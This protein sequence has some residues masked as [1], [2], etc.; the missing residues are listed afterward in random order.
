MPGRVDGVSGR[1]PVLHLVTSG[2]AYHSRPSFFLSIALRSSSV[3]RRPRIIQRHPDALNQCPLLGVK[4]TL[5]KRPPMSAFD[6]KRTL[7][8]QDCCRAN[9]LS[10]IWPIAEDAWR[11]LEA[12][13]CHGS[14]PRHDGDA[15]HYDKR[16]HC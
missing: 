14:R 16:H 2:R 12:V 9:F 13:D 5:P 4:R 1:V 7:A 6:P 15:D 8:A 11:F 10:Q 3:S